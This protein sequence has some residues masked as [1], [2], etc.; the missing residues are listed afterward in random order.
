MPRG[1]RIPHLSPGIHLEIF[2][3]QPY[4]S[5]N[6]EPPVHDVRRLGPHGVDSRREVGGNE[7]ERMPISPVVRLR[8]VRNWY[9]K[10]DQ[11]CSGTLVDDDAV[12]TAAHC[13]YRW[14]G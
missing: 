2:D 1:L 10:T 5:V 14:G 7:A 4:D 9:G 11:F 6:Q 12:L 8:S 3:K 13:V